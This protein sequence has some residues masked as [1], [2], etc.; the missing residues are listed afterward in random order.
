[1][2]V[3]DNIIERVVDELDRTVG[4]AA[5]RRTIAGAWCAAGLAPWTIAG[6][7]FSARSLP[8]R[9]RDGRLTPFRGMV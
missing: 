5:W 6:D 1:M 9:S 7:S 3:E 4:L 2:T 8:A